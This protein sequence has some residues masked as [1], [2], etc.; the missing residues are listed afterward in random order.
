M[1]TTLP[2]ELA[3]AAR[4]WA[5]ELPERHADKRE[6]F[7]RSLAAHLDERLG[8]RLRAGQFV[9]DHLKPALGGSLDLAARD[10]GV[11]FM[12][13]PAGTFVIILKGS[14][15]AR[16]ANHTWVKLYGTKPVGGGKKRSNWSKDTP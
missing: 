12:D 16:R 9:I 4:W 1:T 7:G 10:A 8:D 6:A 11:P 15:T 2:P 13:I 5:A 3:H 14:V